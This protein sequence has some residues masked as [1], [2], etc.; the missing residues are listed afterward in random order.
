ML[1]G[2]LH[3]VAL[4]LARGRLRGSGNDYARRPGEGSAASAARIASTNPLRV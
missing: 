1:A 3:R 4:Q 2:K